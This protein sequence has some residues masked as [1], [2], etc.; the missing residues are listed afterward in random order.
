MTV[1]QVVLQRRR[2]YPGADFPSAP[3]PTEA[4][5][6]LVDLTAW[7]AVH[8]VPDEVVIKT[9]SDRAAPARIPAGGGRPAQWRPEKPQ[10]ADLASALAVRALPWFL[11]RRSP[12][13]YLEEALPG[14]HRGRHAFEWVIEFDR[15]AG[16]R[17][18]L[19]TSCE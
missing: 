9:G 3:G 10:Y 6:H 16:A 12:G 5:E 1:G 4:A 2:W 18:Q 8:A 13:S 17:F 15:P 14:V 19:R 11:E 7:R